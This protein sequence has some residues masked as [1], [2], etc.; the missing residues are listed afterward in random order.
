MIL[1]PLPRALGSAFTLCVT[2]D[3][4]Q[5]LGDPKFLVAGGS[6]RGPANQ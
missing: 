3:S 2:R 5:E 1:Q 6:P 4:Q